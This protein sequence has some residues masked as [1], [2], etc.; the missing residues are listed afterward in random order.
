MNEPGPV[1][2]DRYLARVP[3]P[4]RAV[5]TTLRRRIRAAAPDATEEIAYGM[6][7][8]RLHGPLVYYGAFADHASLFVASPGVRARFV[9]EL[10]A[11]R[12]G[13]ATVHFTPEHPLPAALVRRLIRARVAENLARAARRNAS[14]GRPVS[15][16]SPAGRRS[17]TAP[18]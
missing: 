2:V 18:R 3:P 9:K 1:A 17:G 14:H 13:K 5:L 8:F 12:A 6:P 15:G 16:R 11:F 7:A 10:A 4:L